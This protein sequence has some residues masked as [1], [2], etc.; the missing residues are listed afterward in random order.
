MLDNRLTL[1]DNEE[2]EDEMLE[3]IICMP[4]E[5]KLAVIPCLTAMGYFVIE[6]DDP[7]D[8]PFSVYSPGDNE[9]RLREVYADSFARGLVLHTPV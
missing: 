7:D 6:S 5:Q 4:I 3:E 8:C 2:T 9:T 1:T